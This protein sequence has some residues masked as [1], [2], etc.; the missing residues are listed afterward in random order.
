MIDCPTCKYENSLVVQNC[1][2]CGTFLG[3]PNVNDAK[4]PEEFDSLRSRYDEVSLKITSDAHKNKIKDFE[5]AIKTDARAVVNID[6]DYLE[7]FIVTKNNLYSSYGRA[8]AGETRA[9]A[10][11]EFDKQRNGVEGFLF[12]SYADNIRYATLSLD[13]SGLKSYADY[14]L[15][16]KDIAIAQRAT[17]LEENSYIIVQKYF[18]KIP[19]GYKATWQNKHLLAVVKCAGEIIKKNKTTF[20]EILLKSTGDRKTDDFIEVHIFGPFN[21]E[22]VESVKGSSI[23]TESLDKLKLAKIKNHLTSLGIDW[24]EQ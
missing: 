13:K 12:G 22:S 1:V 8:T 7:T 9:Y 15:S 20:A 3:Y 17:V 19:N 11:S 24:I 16:L 14:S 5:D 23:L 6:L 4:R 18:D 2:S 10:K 21:K